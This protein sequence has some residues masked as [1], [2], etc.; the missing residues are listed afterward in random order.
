M[1][2][3]SEENIKIIEL[4]S[5]E[6][7]AVLQHCRFLDSGLCSRLMNCTNGIL[8]LY[9]YEMSNLR[10]I[11]DQQ[12][13]IVNHPQ[14][15]RLLCTVSNKLCLNPV[16]S[17]L[18]EEL[19]SQNFGSIEELNKHIQK[20][21]SKKNA[22]ADPE[23]GGLSPD[24]VTRLIYFSWDN[25]T[26]PIKFNKHLGI[27]D[28]DK[29]PVFRDARIFLNAILEMK[30]EK[31]TTKTSNLS[32]KAVKLMFDK[33][34]F[35]EKFRQNTLKYNKVLNEAD[36]W[37]IHLARI[38]C[39]GAGIIKRRAGKFFVVK[40]HLD[41]LSDEKAGQLYYLLF[42]AHFTKFN[43]AYRDQL[44]D[45]SGIQK[46]VPYTFYQLSKL[47]K[48]QMNMAGLAPRIFLPAVM[49]EI[50]TQLTSPYAKVEWL[51]RTRIIEPLEIFGLI[52]CSRKK[53]KGYSEIEKIKK[54]P[55]FDKFMKFEL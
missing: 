54:T 24:Q 51:I 30:G 11:I 21:Y 5:Q 23:M 26:F 35:D 38:L 19:T 34:E 36:V 52:E 17:G 48:K 55:L 15:K 29:S 20:T 9:D 27:S 1:V 46:T 25:E 50:N 40:K 12:I 18:A 37:P 49:K 44:P 22:T 32:R 33:F 8:Q 43:L 42:S 13:N 4:T 3:F 53:Q 7:G 31:N 10:A 16:M 14:D 41:M 39:E 6:I 47:A 28:A 2:S 45:V